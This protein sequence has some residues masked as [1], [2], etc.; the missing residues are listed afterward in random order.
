[1]RK[2]KSPSPT[3]I[4]ADMA[5]EA[6]RC[7]RSRAQRLLAGV[8]SEAPTAAIDEIKH[9]ACWN[10]I[11]ATACTERV[12]GILH[13]R[14]CELGVSPVPAHAAE[15]QA[16]ADHV[17]AANRLQLSRALA[18]VD[19]LER[20]SIP[21]LLLKGA[22]LHATLYQ[23]LNARPMVDVDVMIQPSDAARASALLAELGWRPEAPFVR[24]DFFP[25]FHYE[26]PFVTCDEPRVRIDLHVRP[27]RPVR[28]A[29]TVP[30]DAFWNPSR[31]V[32]LCG[33]AVRVPNQSAM[34]IHL[35]VHAACH[36]ASHLR[37]LYDIFAWCRSHA[38]DID[39]ADIVARCHDWKLGLP[40][41]QALQAVRR[42]FGTTSLI[43]AILGALPRQVGLLDRLVMWQ[44]PHGD[45]RH[46]MDVVVNAIAMKGWRRRLAY[47]SAIALPDA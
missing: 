42:T 8:L 15:L 31:D 25:R 36:G 3:G 10:E 38:H 5:R 9:R 40:V 32:T 13:G 34:L 12:G 35:A 19:A 27:F 4:A 14:L 11:V 1:M 46:V 16:Y 44:A 43:D 21:C 22:A 2:L 23:A 7:L 30:T 41:G 17:A 45:D 20:E 29:E 6:P 24:A 28:F 47:M 33:Q 37:W 18:V 26:C 39:A